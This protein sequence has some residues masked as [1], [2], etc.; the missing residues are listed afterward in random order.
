[1]ATMH[2]INC[3]K[4]LEQEEGLG[5]RYDSSAV[6]LMWT[7]TKVMLLDIGKGGPHV[8]ARISRNPR[9]WDRGRAPA[10]LVSGV[11]VVTVVSFSP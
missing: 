5:G 6:R 1:M 3:S 10:F 7:H 11:A 8:R 4:N 2:K 9:G